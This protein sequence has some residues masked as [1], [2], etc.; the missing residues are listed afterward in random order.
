MSFRC[1]E[2]VRPGAG[3]VWQMLLMV[4]LLLAA[5]PPGL[6]AGQTNIPGQEPVADSLSTPNLAEPVITSSPFDQGIT[7]TDQTTGAHSVKTADF[8]RDG[9]LDV[10]IASRDDGAITWLRNLGNLQFEQRIVTYAPGSYAALPADLNRDG[11]VDIVV[12]AVG[13]VDPSNRDGVAAESAAAGAGAIFWL[14]NN[15]P[16]APAF[17]RQDI[18]TGLNYP[19]AIHTV[20]LDNDGDLDVA[21]ASRDD[22]R[23][24]WYESSG[25]PNP[26]FGARLVATDMPGAVAV[27]AGDIDADGYMD[28]VGASEDTNR[29]IWYRN[30]GARPPTFDPRTIRNG[31]APPPA[32]D[33]AKAVF[34]AD[35]DGD[36]DVDVAFASEQQN[37]VGW[38]E[39]QGRGAQFVER[40]LATSADHAKAVLVADADSDGDADILAASSVDSKV[41]LFENTRGAPAG[42]TGRIVTNRALGARAVHAADIDGDGDVDLFSASRDDNRVTLYL[43]QTTHRTALISSQQET[44]LSVQRSAR[45]VWTADMD[46]DGRKDI[47][48]VS[49][50]QVSWYRNEGGLPPRFTMYTVANNLE[51]G[52][53]VATG[54]LDGDGDADLVV[55][56]TRASNI[57]WYENLLTQPGAPPNFAARLVTNQT[58]DPRTVLPGDLDGDGDLDLYS[59]S[60]GDNSVFWYENNGARPPQFVRRLVS[61]QAFYARSAY[62]ADLDGDGDL[63]LMSASASDNEV[64]WY[65]NRGGAPPTFTEH[66]IASAMWGARHVHAEDID[67]DGDID[68]LSGSEL[69]NTIAWYENR[70]GA[71][72]TFVTRYV[73]QRAWGTHA[74]YTADVDKDGDPDVVAAN[75]GGNNV[76]WYE[77][78]GGASPV[79]AEHLISTNNMASH[80]VF[81]D[82]LDADGDV[83][84]LAASRADGKIAWYENLGGQYALAESRPGG[85]TVAGSVLLDVA[86]THRGRSGDAALRLNA[87]TLRFTNSIG[88][89]LTTADLV[90][91]IARLKVYR[92]QGSA[93][94]SP[95]E[96]QLLVNWTEVTLN[97]NGDLVVPLTSP[98]GNTQT[99]AGGTD[100]YFVVAE[101][102]ASGCFSPQNL[103]VAMIPDG[104]TVRNAATDYPMIGEYMRSIDTTIEVGFQ[105][106]I[107]INEIM[108]DADRGYLDPDEPAEY[109][110][111]IELYNPGFLPINLNG[112]YLTDDPAEPRKFRISTDMIVQPYSHVVFLADGEPEQGPLHTNFRLSRDGEYVALHA[113][114]AD[115]FRTIDSIEYE[116]LLA[117]QSYGRD[118]S[119][120][121]QWQVLGTATPGGSNLRHVV[122]SS[123][124]LPL[125]GKTSVCR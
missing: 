44:I 66:L 58:Q 73:S 69:N 47:L 68:V 71:P 36:G 43:N 77:N 8:D 62:A 74:V 27:H 24:A 14:R 79:F 124:Y 50:N 40:M 99:G 114:E 97:G 38:Y 10:V 11:R 80:G 33:Y 120:G 55:A 104:L 103:R 110:D 109:P 32:L 117:N 59:S 123:V 122:T 75:E 111:W 31:P 53:W 35:I 102:I 65:E 105:P 2:M 57:W 60:N 63:D 115:D 95:T 6:A 72:P 26:V 83:D 37:Q 70:G 121:E 7:L 76:A 30:N 112:M 107:V 48:S 22:G 113:G 78:L 89:P 21:G 56:D 116:A 29:I 45:A 12:A 41:L 92:N 17:V 19:V 85:T 16:G 61:N 67:M 46:K 98:L 108:A 9:K 23:I 51:A 118:P 84:V 82:D 42:F 64:S 49:L 20:D 52:R 87:L 100:H 81:A 34:A 3:A 88:Q 96:D 90:G 13:V 106:R 4:G 94:F 39:N 93:A 5:Q 28:L 54:D 1:K 18:A 91:Q 25:G 86:A 119:G 101:A 15:L 125:V